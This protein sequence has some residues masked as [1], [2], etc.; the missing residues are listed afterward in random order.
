MKLILT[1]CISCCLSK[2][3]FVSNGKGEVSR[4]IDIEK[5]TPVVLS[6]SDMGMEAFNKQV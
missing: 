2:D 3:S 6:N 1:Y 5:G 4:D